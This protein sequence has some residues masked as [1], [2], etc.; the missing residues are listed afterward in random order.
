MPLN[1]T[2]IGAGD[3]GEIK[4]IDKSAIRSL[5]MQGKNK[6][7][8]SRRSIREAK[9]LDTKLQMQQREPSTNGKGYAKKPFSS[10]DIRVRKPIHG[11]GLPTPAHVSLAGEEQPL[12]VAPSTLPGWP[13]FEV[14]LDNESHALLSK[15]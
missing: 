10:E 14:D 1:L 3:A 8:D 2:F 12:Y 9:R 7:P 5:V 11:H 15:C 4:A 6:R 13:R